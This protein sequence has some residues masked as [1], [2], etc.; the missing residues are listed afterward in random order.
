MGRFVC[1]NKYYGRKLSDAGFHQA[2]KDFFHNGTRL[3]DEL[4]QPFIR[5]LQKLKKVVEK[6]HSFRFYSSSL[7][8]IYD[9]K[10]SSHGFSCSLADSAGS[11]DLTGSWSGK[12]KP[13]VGVRM[14]DFAHSTHHGFRD[15]EVHH[16][17]DT[18]Y[19]LGL[20]SLTRVLQDIERGSVYSS[21][22]SSAQEDMDVDS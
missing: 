6:Q 1:R 21:C 14:I 7:L 15:H 8:L 3:R 20:D 4:I 13:R 18:G 2:I 5:K 22:S 11:D 12:G 17:P 16:G 9:G 19:I 10:E